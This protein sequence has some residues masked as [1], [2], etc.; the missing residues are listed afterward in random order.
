M[1]EPLE[2]EQ[3]LSVDVGQGGANETEDVVL[4]VV[5]VELT[6]EVV[7]KADDAVELVA[8]KELEDEPEVAALE[9]LDELPEVAGLLDEREAVDAEALD[10]E[11]APSVD[12]L[13]EDEETVERL[14]I[15]EELV[16]AV[17]D[18]DER[19]A[20]LDVKAEDELETE[21]EVEATVEELKA[22]EEIPVLVA[23]AR[24]PQTSP[25]SAG[26]SE[27]DEEELLK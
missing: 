19:L 16:D 7:E 21:L 10:T 1:V 26:D 25:L 6:P 20:E 2:L 14:D 11:E 17:D 15:A 8:A 13:L 3:I 24:T 9:T 4:A 23:V 12:E 22:R 27:F 5:K 18:V